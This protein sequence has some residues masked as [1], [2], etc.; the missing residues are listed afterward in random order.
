MLLVEWSEMLSTGVSEIDDEHK[1]IVGMLN[2]LYDSLQAKH[3]E[4]TLGK[5]LDRLLA[6]TAYHF[7]HE[8]SLLVQTGYPGAAA[9]KNEH[10]DLTN[11]VLLM[12]KDYREA[13]SATLPVELLNV[14]RKWLLT[15]ILVSDKKYVLHLHANGIC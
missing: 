13:K 11:R 4:E 2:D 6:Y 8:E 9:H 15:H 12:Q 10:D 1:Q 3:S 7:E 5:L 14:L